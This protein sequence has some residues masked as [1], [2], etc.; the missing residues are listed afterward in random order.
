VSDEFFT[1][2]GGLAAV[3]PLRISV[4]VDDPHPVREVDGPAVEATI[5]ELVTAA[6]AR[7]RLERGDVLIVASTSGTAVLP[8]ELCQRA[9]DRGLTTVALTS[10]E[11]STRLA[12]RHP[13]GKRLADVGD[14]VIDSAAPYGDGLLQVD[15]VE[16]PC[17]PFSGIGAVTALWAMVARA[18]ELVA[19]E[20]T[21]P[22]VYPSV[23]LPD[24]PALVERARARYIELGF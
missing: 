15:G 22:T 17:C 23:N 12:P 19:A 20:G 6:I 11:Y 4:A 13:S 7:S 9:K 2:A 8:V 14:I 21:A 16:H 18:I 3:V 10:I 5:P 1:R 24:G